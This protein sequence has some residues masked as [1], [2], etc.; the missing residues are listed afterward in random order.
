VDLGEHYDLRRRVWARVLDEI[1][2][3][4]FMALKYE[5]VATIFQWINSSNLVQFR[6]WRQTRAVRHQKFKSGSYK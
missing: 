4:A 6:Q 2:F 3:G 1:G 5:T